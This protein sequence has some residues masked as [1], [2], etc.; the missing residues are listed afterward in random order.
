MKA[1]FEGNKQWSEKLKAQ[2]PN[3]FIDLA[4]GQN[5]EYLSLLET[6]R[7]YYFIK[8]EF[9]RTCF[10]TITSIFKIFEYFFILF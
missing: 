6:F 3:F 7:E 5:P 1:L 8:K 2:D 9:N 10:E 4:K